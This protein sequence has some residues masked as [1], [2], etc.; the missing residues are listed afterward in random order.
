MSRP[1]PVATVPSQTRALH[2]AQEIERLLANYPHDS[3]RV[4]MA[5]ALARSLADE[6]ALIDARGAA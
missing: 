6:I 5:K 2:L 4:R 3:P 1:Q